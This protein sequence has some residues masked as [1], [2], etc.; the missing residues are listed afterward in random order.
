MAKITRRNE[1][2][3]IGKSVARARE[4]NCMWKDELTM[5]MDLELAIQH[6]NIDI[7]KLYEFDDFNFVHDIVGIQKHINRSTLS[8]DN[9]F[10]PRSAR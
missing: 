2:E 7:R 9:R 10:L 6:F 8:F 1:I 5:F 3:L 4:K